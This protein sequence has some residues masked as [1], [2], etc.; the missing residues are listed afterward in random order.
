MAPQESPKTE[1]VNVSSR[2]FLARPHEHLKED[3][4]PP[5]PTFYLDDFA[6]TPQEFWGLSPE[7]VKN[8][9]RDQ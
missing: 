9:G 8:V 3:D 1:L 4:V 6:T 7:N 5:P 2:R